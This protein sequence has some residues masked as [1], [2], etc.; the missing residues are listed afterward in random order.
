MEL[1]FK[2]PLPQQHIVVADSSCG[3]SVLPLEQAVRENKTKQIPVKTRAASTRGIL[4]E[5]LNMEFLCGIS[6]AAGILLTSG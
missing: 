3:S 6:N 4:N 2:L 1:Q 5:S